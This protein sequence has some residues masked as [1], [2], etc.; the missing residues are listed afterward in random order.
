VNSE[1]VHGIPGDRT[2]REGDII[3]IDIGVLKNGYHGDGAVTFPVGVMDDQV[4]KLLE[5]TSGALAAGIA[6]ARE[7]N[8][9]QDMARAIQSVVEGAGFSVVRDLVGHG[10]GRE[11][12]E[13]P[14]VPNFTVPGRSPALVE[15]MTLAVEPMVNMGAP[16]IVIRDD[17]WTVVTKDDTLSA[18]FEHTI[19][20]GK[21]GSEVLTRK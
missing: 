16:E 14:Q 21:E 7:G 17:G 9:I 6:Q 3:S 12:H 19:A 5:T 2:L 13:Q 18:H 15:G 8:A 11:M 4:A 10:I 1:V 20:V